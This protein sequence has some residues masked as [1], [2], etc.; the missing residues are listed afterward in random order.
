MTRRDAITS[1]VT[2]SLPQGALVLSLAVLV[3]IG[4]IVL[5]PSGGF[6]I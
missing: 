2:R 3:L 1:T 5:A 6:V 4:V